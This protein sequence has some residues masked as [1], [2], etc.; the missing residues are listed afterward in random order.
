VSDPLG[1]PDT[2]NP[3]RD[4]LRIMGLVF[5]LGLKAYRSEKLQALIFCILNDTVHL[6]PYARAALWKLEG[7]RPK[8]LGVSGQ[9]VVNTQ[10]DLAESWRTLVA[11]LPAPEKSVRLDPGALGLPTEHWQTVT[12]G[13]SLV[14]WVPLR[15]PDE[16]LGGL[17]L[18]R[19]SD[20]PWTDQ[21]LGLLQLVAEA[22][23]AAWA[24]HRAG[25]LRR[26]LGRIG[27]RWGWIGGSLTAAAIVLLF[28]V[29]LR[30]KVVGDCEVVPKNPYLIT[31]PLD[32]VI[33][34][35]TVKPGQ[36]VRQGEL[37]FKVDGR[38]ARQELEVARQQVQ[39][40]ASRLER[41]TVLALEG[42]K[43]ENEL[44]ILQSRLQ[45]ERH[46]LRLAESTVARL[47][48]RAPVAGVVQLS[49]PDDWRGKPVQ[50][51]QRVLVLVDP[52]RTMV[53]IW[54]PQDDRVPGL[55]E[56]PLDVFLNVAP[57]Q[58]HR[59]RISFLSGFASVSPR[60]L[61]SFMAEADWR[62]SGQPVALGLQGTAILYGR[63]ASL[64]YWLFRKPWTGLRG[65][66]GW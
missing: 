41:A 10:T 35:V 22:Y 45:Q 46:R 15:T 32:G 52:S 8:L 53:R 60:G 7:A 51:G 56:N 57:G 30:L 31:A 44:K 20:T 6:I 25:A 49:D 27:R 28:F 62:D 4:S 26:W 16:Q 24:R 38:V 29:P 17:W 1:E 23:A 19:P 54:I 66:L 58:S 11:A 34:S 39:V 50:L 5:Q 37:L 36:Q 59:A 40:V 18:E 48:V 61:P 63:K 21:D 55:S 33:E 3:A 13:K 14:L 47:E 12:G 65:Q 9:T 2:A 43:T 64:A 42:R